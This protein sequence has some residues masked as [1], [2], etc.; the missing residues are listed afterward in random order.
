LLL[1]LERDS[2]GTA[3]LDLDYRFQLNSRPTTVLEVSN[4]DTP[5]AAV[6]RWKLMHS[7]DSSFD[8]RRTRFGAVRL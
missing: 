3:V 6:L 4:P 5:D 7:V 1:R 8:L 2:G